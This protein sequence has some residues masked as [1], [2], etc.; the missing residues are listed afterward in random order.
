MNK[1]L[2][3]SLVI[4]GLA[5]IGLVLQLPA[6]DDFLG[7][8][9]AVRTGKEGAT[10]QTPLELPSPEVSRG[11][12]PRPEGSPSA[13]LQVD[14][15]VVEDPIRSFKA[16]LV[17]GELT[18]SEHGSAYEEA[19]LSIAQDTI[20]KTLE[21]Q[22]DSRTASFLGFKSWNSLESMLTR[23]ESESPYLAAQLEDLAEVSAAAS[24]SV[25]TYS[26]QAFMDP[27][28][29]ESWD[30]DSGSERPVWGDSREHSGE[31]LLKFQAATRIGDR[32][33]KLHFDSFFF[34]AL[35]VSLTD[36]R[37]RKT[38]FWEQVDSL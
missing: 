36:L 34:P 17:R 23:L 31:S 7:T 6:H 18:R 25:E 14:Q 1:P 16:K 33:Y 20:L 11:E 37:A 15:S 38:E 2:V 35:D 28:H 3:G 29:L 30:P 8:G 27:F 24:S 10:R 5:A 9:P 4:I 19:L 21:S 32:V 26:M 12:L 13:S 22:I